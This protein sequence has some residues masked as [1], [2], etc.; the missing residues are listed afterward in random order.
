MLNYIIRY[1][2]SK[3]YVQFPYFSIIFFNLNDQ[4]RHIIIRIV[5][6]KLKLSASERAGNRNLK[7]NRNLN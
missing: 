4:L 2:A 3:T 5:L 1:N 6:N 7:P